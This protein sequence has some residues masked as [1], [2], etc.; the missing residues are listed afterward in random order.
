MDQGK[1]EHL[2]LPLGSF[3]KQYRSH[4]MVNFGPT[5]SDNSQGRR[6]PENFP[7]SHITGRHGVST[8]KC[9]RMSEFC[10]HLFTVCT[11]CDND[12]D[13]LGARAVTTMYH[14]VYY[15]S[16]SSREGRSE[17]SGEKTMCVLCG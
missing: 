7:A 16:F 11:L 4:S 1:F 5:L 10:C 15:T 2:L 12:A 13:L 8:A 17:E 6:D 3:L 9:P 14:G